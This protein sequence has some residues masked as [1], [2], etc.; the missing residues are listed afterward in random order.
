M[1]KL[2]YKYILANMGIYQRYPINLNFAITYNCNSRCNLCSIWKIKPKNELKLAEIEKIARNAPFIYSLKITGGE[3]FIRKDYVD[4]VRAFHKNLPNLCM[5]STPTNAL[6]PDMVY[7]KVKETLGFFDKKYIISISLDGYKELHEK[8]R[9]V[10]G[11]YDRA[12]YLYKKLLSLRKQFKNFEVMFGYTI[13]PMNTKMF[14]K[15]FMETQKNIGSLTTGDFHFNIFQM[16]DIYYRN[17]TM[18]IDSRFLQNCINDVKIISRMREKSPSLVN[19]V[20]NSYLR[21]S[22]KYLESQKTPMPCNIL[23][24]SCFLDPYGNVFPCITF[25]RK[26]GNLRKSDYDLKKIFSSENIASVKKD[27][28]NLRC[29]NCWTPCEVHQIMMSNLLRTLR[30]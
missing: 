23:D 29:P 26:L 28:K 27:L 6:A 14:E 15:T 9:G 19:F 20:E 5:L 4:I 1:L 16:S 25:N 8:I 10:K 18:K 21:L 12:I 3:P 13:S 7:E 22:K 30:P 17:D 24:L 11:N 2:G